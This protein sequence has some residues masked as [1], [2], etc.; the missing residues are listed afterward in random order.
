MLKLSQKNRKDSTV[1]VEARL[2]DAKGVLCLD[3]S[4]LLSFSLTGAGALI[5]NLGTTRASR[6]VQLSTAE[7]RFRLF[8]TGHAPSRQCRKG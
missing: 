3:A 1:T 8:A 7:L 5:D 2:L 6:E 4:Q